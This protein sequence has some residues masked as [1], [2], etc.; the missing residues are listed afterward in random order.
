M[1]QLR[2]LLRIGIL[3]SSL[4][5][6]GVAC[7]FA[8]VF[9][10][11][12]VYSRNS[13]LVGHLDASK[14]SI[15][16]NAYFPSASITIKYY[17]GYELRRARDYPERSVKIYDTTK[18]GKSAQLYLQKT[19][20][21]TKLDFER[22]YSGG[23][24]SRVTVGLHYFWAAVISAFSGS[25]AAVL[26]WTMVHYKKKISPI[27]ECSKCG[28]DLR[29]SLDSVQCPECGCYMKPG[30]RNGADPNATNLT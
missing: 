22:A 30:Y 5:L 25:L 27:F 24:I 12:L 11:V 13:L 26:W 15:T 21:H 14:I 9:F 6:V 2:K 29:G 3:S 4:L 18:F 1:H 8:I 10:S 16:Y 19:F 7:L 17:D 20:Q 28:Y 23:N